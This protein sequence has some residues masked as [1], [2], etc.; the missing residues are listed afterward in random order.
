MQPVGVPVVPH[1]VFVGEERVLTQR[2][3]DVDG[4]GGAAVEMSPEFLGRDADHNVLDAIDRYGATND[5][6]IG[7]QP[8]L[9]Q[10]VTHHEHR[11]SV[12]NALTSVEG[13]PLCRRYAHRCEVVGGDIHRG[14][15][16]WGDA[17]RTQNAVA[18]RPTGNRHPGIGVEQIFE[19]RV[20]PRFDRPLAELGAERALRVDNHLDKAVGVDARRRGKEHGQEHGYPEDDAETD[21]QRDNADGTEGPCLRECSSGVGQVTAKAG[22]DIAHCARPSVATMPA[23]LSESRAHHVQARG[24]CES[25]RSPAPMVARARRERTVEVLDHLGPVLDAMRRGERP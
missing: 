25:P 7:A 14:N 8:V 5:V 1:A 17:G 10:A 18:D 6:G 15:T 23:S 21:S 20:G 13:P 9:P 22:K 16:L 4:P 2:Q 24:D 12:R 3:P 11:L 19:I